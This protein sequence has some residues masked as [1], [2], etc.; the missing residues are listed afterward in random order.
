LIQI[1]WCN[2]YLTL[3]SSF[4]YIIYPTID[5][6][7]LQLDISS[8]IEKQFEILQLFPENVDRMSSQMCKIF[9]H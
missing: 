2:Y 9:S 5:E 6:L 7:R 4:G 1:F 8:L 3:K